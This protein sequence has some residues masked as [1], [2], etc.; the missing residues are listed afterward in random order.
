MAVAAPPMHMTGYRPIPEDRRDEFHRML[1]EVFGP[2][3]GPREPPDPEDRKNA[4]ERRGMFE[5]DDLQSVCRHY[6]WP[7]R[8]RGEFVDGAGLSAVATPP[9][10]RR[11]G[12]VAEMLA[13]SV[14]EYR[15]RGVVLSALYPFRRSFYARYGWA[16]ACPA[17]RVSAPV[18]ALSF[19]GNARECEFRRVEA[20]DWETVDRAFGAHRHEHTLQI[21]RPETWWR[22]MVFESYGTDPFVY[23]VERDGEV[24]GHVAYSVEETDDGR[25]LRAWDWSWVDREAWL[26]LLRF[27]GDHDSQ[28]DDVVLHGAPWE[29]RDLLDLVADPSPVEYE[30]SPGTM[31]RV[32]DVV[33]ALEAVP[34]PGDVD[35]RLTLSVTDPLVEFT[36]GQYVLE[37]TGGEG[38]CRRAEPG[39]ASD[40]DLRASVNA[41]TQAVVGYRPVEAL[42]R[43]A[44]LETEREGALADI[45]ALF[46]PT[47]GF[48]RDHF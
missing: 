14:R 20:D 4:G 31:V 13:E 2:E 46:P 19:A 32:V 1:V 39:E 40:P 38:T 42:V 12:L 3:E 15:D 21:D 34:Y 26:N 11:R 18:D 5:G 44:A 43:V 24:R 48:M 16:T 36:E 29:L 47:R 23:A 17:A 33:R 22:E 45:G 28:V 7:V 10:H 30:V 9:E 8:L 25:R 35:R 41:L 6:F 27:V 37:V